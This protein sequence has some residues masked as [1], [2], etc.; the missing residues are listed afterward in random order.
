M[1]TFTIAIFGSS[2]YA[3]GELIRLVDGHPNLEAVYLGAH[4]AAGRNLASVHPHLRDGHRALGPNDPAISQPVDLA[5]LALPHGASAEPAMALLDQGAKVVDLGSDFRLDTPERYTA[6]YGV[7]HPFPEQLGRWVYGLPELNREAIADADRVASP[8]CYPTSA[9]LPLAPVLATGLV[10][11]T[12]IIV[13]SMSGVSGAGRGVQAA[14]Q[15]GA[16]D[17]S[18]KAYKI[19]E[20]RHRPEMERA[21]DA[22]SETPVRLIFTPHLVPMQ[23]GILTT[24]YAKATSGTTLEDVRSA[25]DNMY[26]NEPFVSIVDG[27]PETRWVAGSNRALIAA[28]FDDRSGTVVLVSAIDNLVK[29]ASGQAVQAANVMLGLAET[30][31]LPMEGWMP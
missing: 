22:V 5:F 13:D 6:A 7:P 8:G 21:L 29:G 23:R 24:I 9:I 4:T 25:L 15:F 27:S 10:E 14:L 3:G 11:S 26:T 2:G 30:T 28:H 31:G 1:T 16:V 17:E 18:A 12:G 19:L 20:H